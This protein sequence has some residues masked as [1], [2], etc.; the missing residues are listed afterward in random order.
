MN[1]AILIVIYVLG[2]F[3]SIQEVFD[4]LYLIQL[5][6]YRFDRLRDFFSSKSGALF[7][8][9][10]FITLAFF[11]V[12]IAIDVSL[13]FLADNSGISAEF[14]L[15]PL[16]LFTA[17]MLV[18]LAGF[19][20]RALSRSVRFPKVTLR[21]SAALF[22]SFFLY[23][24]CVFSFSSIV[25]EYIESSILFFLAAAPVIALFGAIAT[26]P[27]SVLLKKRIVAQAKEKRENHKSMTVIGI[28]GSYG[29][30]SVKEFMYAVLRTHF[31]VLKTREH[32]NTEIGVAKTVVEN[33][34]S[35]I[36]VFIV[37][38]GAY[39][40]GEIKAI[41]EIVKPTIGV[42]TAVN[43]QH[44]SLFGSINA[45]VNTKAELVF[46]LPKNGFAVLNK[47]N[48]YT[49][50]I[51]KKLQRKTYLYSMED[52]AQIVLKYKEIKNGI[53]F[54]TVSLL[55][56]SISFKT[57]LVGTHN[58]QNLLPV[59]LIAVKIGVPVSKIQKAIAGLKN[60][61]E[62]MEVLKDGD[63]VLIDNTYNLNPASIGAFIDIAQSYEGKKTVL[64]LDDILELGDQAPQIHRDL[65]QRIEKRVDVLILI[66]NNYASII[67]KSLV[68]SDVK[69]HIT[70]NQDEI[71]SIL[72]ATH[73]KVVGFLGRGAK[74]I[75]KG[76][77]E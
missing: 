63:D 61:S 38:M 2:T 5:K 28:T 8:R 53:T 48:M 24:L 25:F 62:N 6:E 40:K 39:K 4:S 45:I 30:T 43:E 13:L 57:K 52:D 21:M 75:L 33:L 41:S 34:T 47:D 7:L 58:V 73:S 66:G 56:K 46:S 50:K 59:I 74:S 77:Y 23:V 31:T 55:N 19:L 65:A 68:G 44:V 42:I 29:K 32:V 54:F 51:A 37:E 16:I 18:Q 64:I 12:F 76:L 1:I 35:D 70:K 22:A 20:R 71:A 72:D 3:L 67:K 14:A 27:L 36:D 69:V 10:R 26:I 17:Y 15:L 11:L 9:K 49:R 60:P